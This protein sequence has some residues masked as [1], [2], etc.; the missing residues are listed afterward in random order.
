M[1][2]RVRVH[3]CVRAP[4]VCV[5]ACVCLCVPVRQQV[6]VCAD[7]PE[8]SSCKLI[9]RKPLK[10]QLAIEVYYLEINIKRIY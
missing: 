7:R 9:M 2:I 4:W 6:L 1:C 5:H 10:N 3:T 8:S